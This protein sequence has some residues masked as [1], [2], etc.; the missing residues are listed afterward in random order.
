MI[1]IY[2]QSFIHHF[3]GLFTTNIHWPAPSWLVSSVG[4]QCC[5][6][7]AE[8]MGSDPVQPWI[9]S[10]PYFHYRVGS[11]LNCKN[12]FFIYAPIILTDFDIQPLLI[13][14]WL[15]IL[16]FVYLLVFF[17]LSNGIPEMLGAVVVTPSSKVTVLVL[18]YIH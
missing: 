8:V 14:S 10:R 7:M 4:S 16:K 5:S 9:F 1:F 17:T 18:S 15:L 2:L 3:M 6:G 13:I 11:V 12:C